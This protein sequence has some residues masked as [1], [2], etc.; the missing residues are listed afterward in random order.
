MTDLSN[1]T[2]AQDYLLNLTYIDWHYINNIPEDIK[3]EVINLI[4]E[5]YHCGYTFND[6]STGFQKIRFGLRKRL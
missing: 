2:K 6:D 4:D 3:T 1:I 5:S